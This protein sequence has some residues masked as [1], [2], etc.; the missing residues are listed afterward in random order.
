[1]ARKTKSL[2]ASFGKLFL[3]HIKAAIR[4]CISGLS[5]Y[6][7]HLQEALAS[8]QFRPEVRGYSFAKKTE[9]GLGSSR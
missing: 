8:I 7:A 6:M 3:S 9:L 2:C 5:D 1:M 4:I